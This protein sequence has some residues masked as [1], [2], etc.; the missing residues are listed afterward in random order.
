MGV[1][2]DM[3]CS[4]GWREGMEKRGDHLDFERGLV[5]LGESKRV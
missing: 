4:V 2:G 1:G 3:L 5:E